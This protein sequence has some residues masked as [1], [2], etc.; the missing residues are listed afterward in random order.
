M[1]FYKE[2]AC[3]THRHTQT[4]THI[5]LGLHPAEGGVWGQC[6]V[7][8][9]VEPPDTVQGVSRARKGAEPGLYSEQ[10]SC[11]FTAPLAGN[12]VTTAGWVIELRHI[13][14]VRVCA[15]ISQASLPFTLQKVLNIN[16]TA[17]RSR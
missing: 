16:S 14:P 2:R 9:S 15:I 17:Q 8:G 5:L 3:H 11:L 13:G 6:K 4:H 7:P 10:V 1:Q 12:A